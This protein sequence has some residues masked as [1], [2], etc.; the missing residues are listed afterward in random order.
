MYAFARRVDDIGDGTLPDDREA[1]LLD[2]ARAGA[3]ADPG[4]HPD[5]PVLVALADAARRLPIPLDA[6]GELVD[7]CEHGRPRAQVRRPRRPRATTAATSPARSAGCRSACS[8]PPS[9][10]RRAREASELADAL[11]VALQLTNILRDIRED[12]INGRVYLPTAD[13]DLFGVTLADRRRRRASTRSGGALAELIRFEA[14]RAWG[15]YDRGPAAAAAARP[16]QRGLLRGDGRHLPR[17]AA[18]HRRRPVAA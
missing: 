6:F 18:A 11:G 7:G 12:L 2:E 4:A 1:Q 5:D 16:P 10:A 8:R 14:A 3:V 9:P 17:A 13:L 15:W